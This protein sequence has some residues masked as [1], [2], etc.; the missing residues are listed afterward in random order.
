M[1]YGLQPIVPP[2][3][4]DFSSCTRSLEHA[5]GELRRRRPF[6]RH[7][8]KRLC[9]FSAF[10][11]ILNYSRNVTYLPNKAKAGTVQQLPTRSSTPV[12]Y[13]LDTA[14]VGP[15]ATT[16]PASDLAA[17]AIYLLQQKATANQTGCH[18][19]LTS[20]HHFNELRC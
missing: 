16:H 19:T 4:T 9:D 6:Y 7:Y 1:H 17:P 12:V 2:V 10:C 5:P 13:L 3:P 20:A 11:A 18:L 14:Y 8:Y 15:Q